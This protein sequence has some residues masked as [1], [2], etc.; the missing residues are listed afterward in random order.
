MTKL[1]EKAFQEAARLSEQEQD[2]LAHAVLDELEDYV[3][4]HDTAVQAKIE[5]SNEDIRAGRTRPAA[6]LLEEARK[7]SSR[8]TRTPRS[9]SSR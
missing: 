1:L 7:E 9:R 5:K 4:L 6:Q 3:E 2:A 8:K